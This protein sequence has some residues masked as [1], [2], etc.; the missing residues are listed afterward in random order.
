[1]VVEGDGGWID[2][3]DVDPSGV[4]PLAQPAKTASQAQW[5]AYAVSQ[6]ADPALAADASRGE[7]IKGYGGK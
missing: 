6:G 2:P 5:A 4:I 1:M 7:L 3:D